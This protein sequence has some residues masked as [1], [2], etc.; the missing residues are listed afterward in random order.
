MP[1]DLTSFARFCH[2]IRLMF[3]Y[4][5]M[6]WLDLIILL[7]SKRKVTKGTSCLFYAVLFRYNPGRAFWTSLPEPRL[8]KVGPHLCLAV[9]SRCR[10]VNDIGWWTFCVP[11]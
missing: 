4:V 2:Q 3:R 8:T 11:H 7:N 5:S 6:S 1:S 10:V 9:T